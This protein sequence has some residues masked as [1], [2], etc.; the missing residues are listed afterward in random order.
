MG[1]VHALAHPA[2]GSQ[3]DWSEMAGLMSRMSMIFKAKAN[4]H[5]D[6]LE[7]PDETL[8]YSYQKQL[9]Q[10]QKVK[11]GLATLVTAK[12][13]LQLQGT[14]LQQQVETLNGQAQQA[15]GAGRED[16]ARSALERR[17]LI[18]QQVQ[19][20]GGQ[21]ADLEQQQQRMIEN[22]RRLQAAVEAFRTRKE[23]IK[24]QY[25]AAEA[26]VQ[27]GE[28]QTG[29]S[30]EMASVGMAIDRATDKT[31]QMQARA[32]AVSELT[33]AGVLDNLLA[34]GSSDLDRELAKVSGSKAVDAELAAM[35]AQLGSGT[36]QAA[37]PS[38]GETGTA[39]R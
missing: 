13:R 8:D 37:L 11:Q 18:E 5:L 25:T 36:P 38:A 27:I 39:A 32:A 33:D 2:L 12:K 20:M 7:R 16:L 15:I 29:L 24:A 21:I 19:G 22:E 34:P 6:S 1:S 4:K 26:Q 10:L 31:E 3:A 9:E 14:Q 23:V 35:K 17:V 28:A 30:E